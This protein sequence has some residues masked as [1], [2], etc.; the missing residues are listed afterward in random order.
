MQYRKNL[1]NLVACGLVGTTVA[2]AGAD[3][4]TV[5]AATTTSIGTQTVEGRGIPADGARPFVINISGATLMETFLKNIAAANDFL[6]VDGDGDR[7]QDLVAANLATGLPTNPY[8]TNLWWV[9]QYRVVGSVNGY[10]ELLDFGRNAIRTADVGF[11]PQGANPLAANVVGPLN[12]GIAL[13]SD[14]SNPTG[15]INSIQYQGANG[16][17]AGAGAAA[18]NSN[19]EGALPVRS[20]SFGTIPGGKQ[21]YSASPYTPGTADG[22]TRIDIA[23]LDVP[24]SWGTTVAGTPNATL[25][26]LDPGYGTNPRV[27]R[28][29]NGTVNTFGFRLV[30]VNPTIYSFGIA[31]APATDVIYDAEFA[32]TPVGVIVNLGVGR[33]TATYSTLRHLF[34]TGR[35]E[36]GENLMAVTRDTGSG[37]LNAFANSVCI[38]PSHCVGEA[39]GGLSGGSS[40]QIGSTFSPSNKSSSGNMDTT[41]RNHRLGIGFSGAERGISASFLPNNQLEFLGVIN[42]LQGRT[43][44]ARPSIENVLGFA[45]IDIDNPPVPPFNH[46]LLANPYDGYNIGGPGVMSTLGDPRSTLNLD[47]FGNPV[48]GSE[49]GN[50]NQAMRNVQ[51]AAF[52]NNITRSTDA[53][54]LGNPSFNT[55]G[56]F[57]AQTLV[58]NGSQAFVQD[59]SSPCSLVAATRNDE[60][61]G[62]V[63]RINTLANAAFDTFGTA[64]L[65]GRTP[66]RVVLTGT[67]RYSDNRGTASPNNVYVQQDGT[68]LAYNSDN[69]TTG[70]ERGVTRRN[71]I[72]G[73]F[74]GDGLRNWN[75]A[76]QM[77]R[78]YFDRINRDSTGVTFNSA[79]G[80][81]WV[82]PVG[83]GAIAGAASG[84][85]CIEIL[86]DF[87]GDGNFGR[88]WNGSAFVSNNADIRYWADGLALNPSTGAL[89]R[90]EGFT[91]V[92][93]AALTVLGTNNFFG[94]TLARGTY[95]AGDSVADVAGSANG[96]T[97]GYAPINSDGV[98]NATD[99]NYVFAQ[100]A[101]NAR[102]VGSALNW[103]NFDEAQFGVNSFGEQVGDLSADLTGDLVVDIADVEKIF[104]ILETTRCD[105]NLDGTVD[106][107][108]RDIIVANIGAVVP[109]VVD[110]FDG[111]NNGS[112]TDL[113]TPAAGFLRGDV[114]GDGV[115]TQADLDLCFAA[116]VCCPGDADASGAVNFDDITSVLGNFGSTG[117]VGQNGNGDA[118]CNGSVNFDDVTTVLGNFGTSCN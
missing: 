84:D 95:N 46:V 88:I 54:V 47:S 103:V 59:R 53:F 113:I 65:N 91:R 44:A 60:L 100:F 11:N 73:D 20:Y 85:A 79:P 38:D 31:P 17:A 48:V 63:G 101:R 92:D 36:T 90:M 69:G 34:T 111:N 108:D 107:A 14:V 18:F 110:T 72:M 12:T 28:N 66:D 83:T 56:Q 43:V 75:D 2:V 22:G 6:D 114:N 42:D 9:I 37:T 41:T 77:V 50:V 81:D 10:Q 70:A 1:L 97:I 26:P 71:R 52:I 98:V 40:N 61:I 106:T 45:S 74:N 118:D 25:T 99:I 39:I 15:Y 4:S 94:T 23:P 8:N 57:L 102:V 3:N 78:A 7:I 93:N 35:T 68:T 55:P 112:R 87:N 86:G 49:P 13:S 27:N 5:P 117:T 104:S 32:Y 109:Q 64:G 21:S 80:T 51:A 116:P 19:H 29:A 82:A 105:V 76:E 115:V 24:T 58:I 96:P 89:N 33:Q 16:D 30:D 62:T 67:G